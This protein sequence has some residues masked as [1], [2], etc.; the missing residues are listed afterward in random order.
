MQRETSEKTKKL[1]LQ[2]LN[3]PIVEN[4]FDLNSKAY[5]ESICIRTFQIR[6]Y[7]GIVVQETPF[8]IKVRVYDKKNKKHYHY[9]IHKGTI[10]NSKEYHK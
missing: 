4:M 7:L 9:N 10:I 5:I 1:I 3:T 8:S 2:L 6:T